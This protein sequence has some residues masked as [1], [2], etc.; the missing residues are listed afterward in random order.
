MSQKILENSPK[1]LKMFFVMKHH[2]S[3]SVIKPVFK[4]FSIHFD[5]LLRILIWKTH[6]RAKLT[7]SHMDIWVIGSLS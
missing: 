6:P 3:M 4:K 5:F 1:L 2:G 7:W